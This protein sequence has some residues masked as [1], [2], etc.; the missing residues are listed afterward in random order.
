MVVATSDG[1][2]GEVSESRMRVRQYI[3]A[4]RKT[5]ARASV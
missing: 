1:A 5:R 4:L 2:R 3:Y